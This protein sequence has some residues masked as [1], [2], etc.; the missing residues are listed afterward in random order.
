MATPS[1][2]SPIKIGPH[3]L[4]K[5]FIGGPRGAHNPT[6]ELLKEASGIFGKETLLVQIISLGCGRSHVS[7]MDMSTDTTGVSRLVQEMAADCDTVE[8]ELATRFC[9]VDVYLRLNVD[10]RMENLLMNEWNNLGSIETYT[11]AYAETA[12]VSEAL[13]ASLK[14]LRGSTGTVTLGQISAYP[15]TNSSFCQKFIL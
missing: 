12:I 14:R 5:S 15:L 10:K 1:Y 7:F 11:S 6:R 4:Q 9:D 2:F 13:E 8:K 3:R